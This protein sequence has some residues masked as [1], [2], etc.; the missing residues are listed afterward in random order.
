MQ[1]N[2]LLT[3]RIIDVQNISP[4]HAKV[5]MEPFD[6]DTIA[7]PNPLIISGKF[8]LDLYILSPG[9]LIRFICSITGSPE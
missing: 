3:P 2:E 1:G 5:I 7:I 9:L 4:L 6:V 8:L